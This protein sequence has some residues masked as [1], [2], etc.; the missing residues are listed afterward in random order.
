MYVFGL[1]IDMMVAA[2][3]FSC[4]EM[5]RILLERSFLL[6]SR[7]YSVLRSSIPRS[8]RPFYGH[9]VLNCALTG[10]ATHTLLNHPFLLIA[11]NCAHQATS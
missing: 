1:S 8:P 7:K 4:V 6:G 10:Q 2:L 3:L 11:Y 5:F 9:Y